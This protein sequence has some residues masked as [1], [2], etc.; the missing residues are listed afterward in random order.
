MEGWFLANSTMKYFS[1]ST[2]KVF[3]IG[4]SPKK[5]A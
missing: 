5:Q 4:K 1:F 2:N 3:H